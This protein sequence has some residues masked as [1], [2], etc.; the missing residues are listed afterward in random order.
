MKFENLMYKG[1]EIKI[2]VDL[3][4]K[5]IE[6]NDNEEDDDNTLDLSKINDDYREMEE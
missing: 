6:K 3:D 1:K 5:F 4:D 2:I